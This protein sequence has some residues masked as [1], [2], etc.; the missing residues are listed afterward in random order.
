[1]GGGAVTCHHDFLREASGLKICTCC[2]TATGKRGFGGKQ[3]GRSFADGLEIHERAGR[4]EML[5]EM[6]NPWHDSAWEDRSRLPPDYE[7]RL[8]G[9]GSF[10]LKVIDGERYWVPK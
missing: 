5:D 4:Y 1:M 9:K 3:P 10:E 8:M 2:G 7:A 6:E